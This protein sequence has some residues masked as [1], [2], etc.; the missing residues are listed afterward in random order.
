MLFAITSSL[1]STFLLFLNPF[2][3]TDWKTSLAAVEQPYPLESFKTEEIR[4][5]RGR[6]D[7]RK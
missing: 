3:I 5:C 7:R 2:K 1:K 4:P 6:K